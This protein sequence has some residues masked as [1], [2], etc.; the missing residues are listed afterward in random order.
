MKNE[1]KSKKKKTK[2]LE[3]TARMRV[4]IVLSNERES[5]PLF[6]NKVSHL[7]ALFVSLDVFSPGLMSLR[8]YEAD[9]I[10]F[11]KLY[12]YKTKSWHNNTRFT[13][14][15]SL[16]KGGTCLITRMTN[17]ASDHIRSGFTFTFWNCSD[18]YSSFVSFNCFIILINSTRCVAVIT[19]A[20]WRST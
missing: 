18:F 9:S 14:E 2:E 4:F 8:C 16:N 13:I 12:Y 6:L 7:S 19:P 5:S 10:R 20:L 11:W 17:I 15:E 1:S 3:R